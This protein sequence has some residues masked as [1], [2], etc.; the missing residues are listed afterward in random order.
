MATFGVKNEDVHGE[1]YR[2]AGKLNTE[3]FSL[4]FDPMGTGLLDAVQTELMEKDR[5]SLSIRAERY[6]LNVYGQAQN[7]LLF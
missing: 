3:Y 2:K 5:D 6:K 7:I 1:S 4:G